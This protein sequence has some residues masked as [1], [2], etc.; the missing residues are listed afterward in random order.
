MRLLLY[1]MGV[2]GR[3]RGKAKDK[4]SKKVGC[5]G[6][7]IRSTPAVKEQLVLEAEK[8]VSFVEEASTE[9]RK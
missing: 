7:G 4:E 8:V 5:L 6:K 3:I 9:R 2:L 1:D